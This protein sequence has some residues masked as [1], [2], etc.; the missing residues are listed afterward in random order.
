MFKSLGCVLLA[1]LLVGC[2]GTESDLEDEA[3]FEESSEQAI[4]G[5]GC[6]PGQHPTAYYCD[7]FACGALAC[8]FNNSN[9]TTCAV[10]PNCGTIT[11]C[12]LGCPAGFSAIA[13]VCNLSCGFC[14]GGT[15][16]ATQCQSNTSPQGCP[17]AALPVGSAVDR[18]AAGG[19]HYLELYYS[20][21]TSSNPSIG[22]A[23]FNSLSCVNGFSVGQ[24]VC[25]GSP[26]SATVTYSDTQQ[27][28]I[29]IPA[30]S[31][32]R[33]CVAHSSSTNSQ[34]IRFAFTVP[35]TP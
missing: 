24:I 1:S 4:C 25:N 6:P 31:V 33:S 13:F 30:S 32:A 10:T 27:L 9:A 16:N 28:N 29:A 19:L 8:N 7:R 12:G 5:I 20:N 15:V 35:G 18:G 34:Y 26:V 21:F 2:V 22:T 23:S 11:Q 17:C 14:G 3:S